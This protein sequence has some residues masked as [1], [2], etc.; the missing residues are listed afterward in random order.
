MSFKPNT[1]QDEEDPAEIN[2]RKFKPAYAYFVLAL[3]LFCRMCVQW[4][5]KGFGFAYGY[6][7]TGA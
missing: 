2:K 4:H 6:T 3:V 5:W 1:I 7:G